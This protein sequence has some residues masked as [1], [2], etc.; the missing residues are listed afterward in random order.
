MAQRPD[1]VPSMVTQM[2]TVGEQTGRVDAVLDRLS[3]F[4]TREID[5]L[6]LNLGA[7]I[8][9]IVIVI[10]GLGVAGMVLA[11]ILPMY[12]VAQSVG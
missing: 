9:P 1:V 2:L 6:V 8:E 12:S 7:L 4:Y 3:N 10:L 5:N 11:V